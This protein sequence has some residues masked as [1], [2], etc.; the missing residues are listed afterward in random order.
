MD[1]EKK[2]KFIFIPRI[3]VI[4]FAAFLLLFSFDVFGGTES[5]GKQ[6]LGF[7]IHSIP[8]LLML[9]VLLFTWK[10]PKVAGFLFITFGIC[11]LIQQ[12]SVIVSNQGGFVSLGL[13]YLIVLPCFLTGILFFIADKKQRKPDNNMPNFTQPT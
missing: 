1:V 2:S 13:L 12:I 3:L 4:V 7:I 9:I 5:L 10:R 6:I 11:A 8:S